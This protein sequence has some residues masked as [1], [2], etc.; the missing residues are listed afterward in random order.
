MKTEIYEIENKVY[1]EQL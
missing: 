1:F